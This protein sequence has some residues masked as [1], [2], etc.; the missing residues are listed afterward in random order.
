MADGVKISE[1]EE[2]KELLDGSCLPTISD[3]QNRKI[4][5]G[6]LKNQL[7]NEFQGHFAAAKDITNLVTWF[8]S[9]TM[10]VRVTDPS[11]IATIDT[12]RSVI[13]L[14]LAAHLIAPSNS[15]E[16]YH[17]ITL[18]PIPSEYIPTHEVIGDKIKIN[19]DGIISYNHSG[20]KASKDIVCAIAYIKA[21]E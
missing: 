1:F 12:E 9:G 3:G 21:E 6:A 2:I 7:M 16:G 14:F 5:Y 8:D 18:T 17:S 13:T 4:T 10:F 19:T 15:K 20:G 11:L